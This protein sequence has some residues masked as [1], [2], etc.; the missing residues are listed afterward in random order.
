MSPE[1]IDGLP[2]FRY[3]IKG[4]PVLYF[5]EELSAARWEEW[6]RSFA[7]GELVQVEQGGPLAKVEA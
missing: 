1:L 5:R 4:G 7:A 6:Q 2:L 3:E